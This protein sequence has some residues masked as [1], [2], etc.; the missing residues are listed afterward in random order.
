M[1]WRAQRWNF[2]ISA[3]IPAFGFSVLIFLFVKFKIPM[4]CPTLRHHRLTN[5]PIHTPLRLRREDNNHIR[6]PPTTTT[7]TISIPSPNSKLPSKQ[8]SLQNPRLST[9][10][11]HNRP[12]L[13]RRSRRRSSIFPPLTPHTS[14]PPP[15]P[16]SPNPQTSLNLPT[17]STILHEPSSSSTPTRQRLLKRRRLPR[18]PRRRE[19]VHRRAVRDGRGEVLPAGHGE[20]GAELGEEEY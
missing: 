16:P 17:P 19:M 2:D 5:I 15:P 1:E 3:W 8:H 9:Y 4:Y 7:T 18:G 14:P 20:E 10:H 6:L 11:H 12:L 13:R